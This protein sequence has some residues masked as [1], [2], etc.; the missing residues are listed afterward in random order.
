MELLLQKIN[1]LFDMKD[2]IEKSMMKAIR[3]HQYGGP[4]VLVVEQINAPEPGPGQIKIA[5][6]AA[7]VNQLDFKLRA[8]YLHEMMPVNFPSGVGFNASGIVTA[9]GANVNGVAIGDAVLGSGQSTMAEY[10]ILNEWV[11]KPVSLSFEEAAGYPG[12]AETAV[13]VLEELGV[14]E[15]DTLLVSGAAGGVGSAVIQV[16]KTM[17][18]H[19]IGTASEIRHDYLKGLGTIP[20]TYGPGLV[21]RVTALA[22]NGVQAAVDI[23]GSGILPDL[24]EI[25]GNASKVLTL[26]D[27]SADSYG[28]KSSFAPRNL[29]QS[30][31]KVVE[32]FEAGLFTL[33]IANIFSMN[34]IAQAQELSADGHAK[35]RIIIRIDEV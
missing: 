28:A 3:F 15:G 24:I 33:P 25:T 6:K 5:V 11:H 18:I 9:I 2:N 22:P 31:Q 13:R 12:P 23:A 29:T 17:G 32:L 8:G 1:S 21:E 10:A 35:G 27:F 19:T 14:K 7:G 20:T 26:G 4:D 30:L 34:E 16:A